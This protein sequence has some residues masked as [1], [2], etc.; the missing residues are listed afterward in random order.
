ML[1]RNAIRTP[2]G[3][4]LES[5]SVHDY[6]THMDTVTNRQY[7]IDGGLHYSRRSAWGDEQE[8]LPRI[9]EHYS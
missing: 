4:I 3:T 1:I 7:M 2:D 9:R 6:R 8:P 5:R